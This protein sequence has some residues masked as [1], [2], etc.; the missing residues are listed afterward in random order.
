MDP[1]HGKLEK[2]TYLAQTHTHGPVN[3]YTGKFWPT[4]VVAG[5]GPAPWKTWQ[6]H[7]LGTHTHTYTDPYTDL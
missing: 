3:G 1:C 6:N 2:T 5:N 4:P 7:V